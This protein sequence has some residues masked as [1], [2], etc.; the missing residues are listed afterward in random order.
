MDVRGGRG[1]SPEWGAGGALSDVDWQPEE[2]MFI[3]VEAVD[4]IDADLQYTT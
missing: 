1:D 3:G 2:A 4:A